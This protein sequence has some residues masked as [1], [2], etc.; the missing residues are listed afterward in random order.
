MCGLLSG[1]LSQEGGENTNGRRRQTKFSMCDHRVR[2][3]ATR[4]PVF[5]GSQ[6][7]WRVGKRVRRLPGGRRQCRRFETRGRVAGK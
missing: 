2:P 5:D 6:G 3:V 4:R 1:D 7:R